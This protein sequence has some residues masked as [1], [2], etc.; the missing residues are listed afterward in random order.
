M[1]NVATPLRSKPRAAPAAARTT[2]LVDCI[3]APHR[4]LIVYWLIEAGYDVRKGTPAAPSGALVD[5][6]AGRLL[7]TDRFGIG[8]ANGATI[9][10]LRERRPDLHVIVIGAGG[11]DEPAQ[12]ALARAAGADATLP[13]AFDRES[14]LHLLQR[15]A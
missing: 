2:V 1:P 7:F 14:V 13:A 4:D 6:H 10:Q 5:R 3:D 12:L 11:A 15:W 8:R 9:L